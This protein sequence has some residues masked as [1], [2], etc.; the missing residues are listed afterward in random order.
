MSLMVS[1]KVGGEVLCWVWEGRDGGLKAW[2]RSESSVEEDQY[3]VQRSGMGWCG[4]SASAWRM[5]EG[6]N[7]NVPETSSG[8]GHGVWG[9]PLIFLGPL[10]TLILSSFTIFP[11]SPSAS[12]PSK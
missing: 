5:N 3:V 9:R 4:C 12:P 10:A 1:V 8:Q 11:L 7:E 6:M 2:G